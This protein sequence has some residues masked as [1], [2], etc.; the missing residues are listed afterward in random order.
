VAG[1]STY[2]ICG[3]PPWVVEHFPRV[4]DVSANVDD[5]TGLDIAVVGGTIPSF[6][7]SLALYLA[8]DR[9][10]LRRSR[11]IATEAVAPAR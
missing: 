9:L 4:L 6:A 8:L 10:L 1:F 5:W 7:V 2:I 11:S 3:L